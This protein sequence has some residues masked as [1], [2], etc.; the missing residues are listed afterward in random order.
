MGRGA[1]GRRCGAAAERTARAGDAAALRRS[2]SEAVEAFGDTAVPEMLAAIH[3]SVVEARADSAEIL[4]AIGGAA[5]VRALVSARVDDAWEVRFA[6]VNAL[7]ESLTP[8]SVAALERAV[9]D[10]HGSVRMLAGRILTDMRDVSRHSI[11]R[12]F[13]RCR[14]LVRRAVARRVLSCSA[15]PRSLVLTTTRRIPRQVARPRFHISMSL[16]DVVSGPRQSVGS[17]LGAGGMRLHDWSTGD[18]HLLLASIL[19]RNSASQLKATT[20]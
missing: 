13:F 11:T 14:R 19:R 20:S 4:G 9:S 7:R 12:H 18:S 3:R 15:F 6:V 16:D 17:P 5:A 2:V 1:H 8:T 10:P